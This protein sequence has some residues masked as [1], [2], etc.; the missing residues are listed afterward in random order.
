A[1]IGQLLCPSG[2]FSAEEFATHVE[3]EEFDEAVSAACQVPG[4]QLLGDLCAHLRVSQSQATAIAAPQLLRRA[5]KVVT[6][7]SILC[8][9]HLETSSKAVARLIQRPLK[10]VVREAE[11]CSIGSSQHLVL[12]A[13]PG[14]VDCM[15]LQAEPPQLG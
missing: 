7:G 11:L 3:F 10:M 6:A 13:F 2:E 12:G 5:W 9:Q 8:H 15:Y 14:N 4:S 1:L